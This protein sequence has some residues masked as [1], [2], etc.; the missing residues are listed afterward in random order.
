MILST[1]NQA[2]YSRL[3]ADNGTGG[4]YEGNA[5]TL[6]SGAWSIFATPGPSA[7]PRIVFG[8]NLEGVHSTTAD[9]FNVTVQMSVFDDTTLI[10]ENSPFSGR[11][12]LIINRIHGD[13]VLQNGRTPT[14]G[15]NRHLLVL[16]TN[17]YTAKAS[18]CLITGVECG[19][20]DE[21]IVQ[22]TTSFK[23][24]VTA[25]ANNP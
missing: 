21:K 19:M 20:V 12:G 22:A 8:I 14:Y 15:F 13:A 25:M 5:W 4:I 16:P 24:R 18:W 7:F 9:E 6:V 23:F 11:I 10:D 3:K 17:G 1:I 2:I